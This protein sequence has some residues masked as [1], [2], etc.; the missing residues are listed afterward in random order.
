MT[1]F[2]SVKEGKLGAQGGSKSGRAVISLT[3]AQQQSTRTREEQ[4][5]IQGQRSGSALP[6]KF[7]VMMQV[8]S[9]PRVLQVSAL[10]QFNKIH[11]REAELCNVAQ[12]RTTSEWL[13]NERGPAPPAGILLQPC[14]KQQQDQTAALLQLTLSPHLKST[15]WWQN[16]LRAWTFSGKEM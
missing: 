3:R 2:W 13:L 5:S 14:I 8:W 15:G 9:P 1:S 16:S 7:T 4:S 10:A 11:R 6:G 12:A